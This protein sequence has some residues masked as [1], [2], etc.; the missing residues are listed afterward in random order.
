MLSAERGAVEMGGV[1]AEAFGSPVAEATVGVVGCQIGQKGKKCEDAEDGGGAPGAPES[2]RRAA[3]DCSF[4]RRSR[5]GRLRGRGFGKVSGFGHLF[6]APRR[7]MVRRRLVFGV[8]VTSWSLLVTTGTT[9]QS[10]ARPER[11]VSVG[12][13]SPESSTRSTAGR[14]WRCASGGRWM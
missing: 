8:L 11:V 12:V 6:Q 3:V 10:E 4:G 14:S 7:T 13:G 1:A 9:S 2:R 5:L